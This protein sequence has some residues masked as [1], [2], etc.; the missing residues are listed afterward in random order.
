MI[1][2]RNK[3]FPPRGL[4]R[5]N[6][7]YLV[8]HA[9]VVAGL[10]LLAVSCVA[11]APQP[12]A[13]EHPHFTPPPPTNLKV[14][15]KTLTGEQVMEIMHGWR[16]QLGVECNTCHTVDPTKKMPNGRPAMNFP[17]DSKPEKEAARLMVKMT[18]EINKTTS[19]VE[20][21]QNSETSAKQVTC[22]TC[23][24]G[25]FD[26]PAYVPPPDHEHE[27]HDAPAPSEKPAGPQ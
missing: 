24:R 1:R 19:M 2:L 15:P 25:K 20:S 8:A 12:A 7:K 10:T 3:D 21:K 26:P 9:A 13:G 23:H 22:G 6:L 18:M 5:L 11:Q 16:Q 4:L 14:L 17:D 27:H